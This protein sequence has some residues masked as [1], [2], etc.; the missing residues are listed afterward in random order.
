MKKTNPEIMGEVWK[1]ITR[2]INNDNPYKKIKQYYNKELLNIKDD[3]NNIIINSNDPFRTA[4]KLSIIGNL[5]DFTSKNKFSINDLKHRLNIAENNNFVIDNSSQ[6]I[7]DLKTA[8]SLL[9]LGDNCG[10]I[11]LDKLFIEV[12]K[13][14]YPNL[15][16]FYGVRGKPIVNDV[17]ID[18]ALMVS[19][20]EVA[21]VISNGDLAIGTVL[22]NTS[23]EFQNIYY[24]SDIVIC[25]GQ[26]NYESLYLSNKLNLYFLFMTKCEIT[27]DIL[28]IPVLSIVCLKNN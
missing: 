25:K 26:G 4:L 7:E 16:V 27:A 11:V 22:N 19:M 21:E 12:I 17:T 6:M 14:Y 8:E 13:K 20:S 9:Y 15:K 24:N 2:I 1:I 3:L 5:I 28:K 23:L 18:D 10:E